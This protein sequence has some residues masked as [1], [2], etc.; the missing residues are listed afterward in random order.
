[1]TSKNVAQLSTVLLACILAACQRPGLMGATSGPVEPLDTTLGAFLDSVEGIDGNALLVETMRLTDSSMNGF[2]SLHVQLTRG[3]RSAIEDARRTDR[4]ESRS[5]EELW[6][7]LNDAA[8]FVEPDRK[9]D[10]VVAIVH[11]IGAG[12]GSTGYDLVE[13]PDKSHWGAS[14]LYLLNGRKLIAWFGVFHRYGLQ[15]GDFSTRAGIRIMWLEQVFCVGAG[16]G[17]SNRF[18]Y[19]I[20][21]DSV[22]SRYNLLRMAFSNGALDGLRWWDAIARIKME[23]PLVVDYYMWSSWGDTD[24]LLEMT[25]DSVRLVYGWDAEVTPEKSTDWAMTRLGIW[26]YQAHEQDTEENLDLVFTR[27]HI[28]A[29]RAEMA[30]TDT[31]RRRC[32][33]DFLRRTRWK[34]SLGSQ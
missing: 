9:G 8:A 18:Y 6:K 3:L 20:N 24:S 7:Q 12:V 2:K 26:S 23:D 34:A 14:E 27:A 5:Y 11:R 10:S 19:E 30:S 22:R 13:V 28:G 1:M 17:Q 25:N 16:C 4:L 31:V 21:G 15:L 33:R 29:L 32:V